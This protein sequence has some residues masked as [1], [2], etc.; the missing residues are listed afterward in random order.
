MIEY[1]IIGVIS[2]FF[3]WFL[4]INAMTWKKYKEKIPKPLLLILYPIVAV[5]YIGD[6]LFNIIFGTV[7]FLELPHYKRLTLTARMQRLL[8]TDGG[9]RFKIAY[10]ICRKL[11]EPWDPNHCGLRG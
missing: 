10:F 2:F 1:V 3:L 9:W 4:F 7:L 8:I 6:I 5:G 11:L